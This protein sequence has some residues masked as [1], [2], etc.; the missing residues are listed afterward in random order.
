M[1]VPDP[2]VRLPAE[3]VGL[4]GV[5]P[6]AA[7]DD[8]ALRDAAAALS[9]DWATPVRPPYVFFATDFS[10]DGGAVRAAVKDVVESVTNMPCVLGENL[11][12]GV[13]QSEILQKVA[14]ATVVLADI[15]GD[16]PNVFLEI[17]AARVADVPVYLL[18]EGPSARPPFMLRDH[19]VRGYDNPAELLGRARSVTYPY[20]RTLLDPDAL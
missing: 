20:R 15:T 14:R 12:A 18:R 17:G 9:E 7:G 5:A 4:P 16:S 10:R 11:S 13:V 8:K 6:P 2:Q 1:V 3:L 19:E